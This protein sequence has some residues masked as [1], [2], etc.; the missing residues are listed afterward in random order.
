MADNTGKSVEDMRIRKLNVTAPPALALPFI[1]KGV[2]D[3]GVNLKSVCGEGGDGSFSWLIRFDPT[4][5]KLT[6]GG[7]PPTSDPFGVGYCFVNETIGDIQVTPVSITMTKGTDGT[8]SSDI[9]DK[10][11]VPIYVH[12]DPNNV[13]VL[14]LTKSKVQGVALSQDGNCIGSY[15]PDG[16]ASPDPTGVCADQD[17]SSCQRWRTQGSLG[18][19]ITL[20]EA[21]GVYIQDLGRSLCVLLTQGSHTANGGKNCAADAQGNITATGDFCSQ[22]DAPATSTCADSFWLAATFAASAALINDGSSDKAC[23]GSLLTAVDAGTDAAPDAASDAGSETGD[24]DAGAG[25]A[26]GSDATAD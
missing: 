8:W 14:P 7:A 2:I 24:G 17:P 15:N 9:I 13:I 22:T 25:D 16:V 6:T 23:N 21:D 5:G 20:K 3:L 11:N 4:T 10:L 1:Q 26:G 12:G 19:Y 18:G